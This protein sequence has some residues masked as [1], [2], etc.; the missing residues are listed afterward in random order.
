MKKIVIVLIICSF[1]AC[2][3]EQVSKADTQVY[4]TLKKKNELKFSKKFPQNQKKL[5]YYNDFNSGF[6]SSKWRKETTKNNFYLVDTMSNS[7][8]FLDGFLLTEMNPTGVSGKSKRAEYGITAYDSIGKRKFLS[9]TIK[10]QKDFKYDQVNLGRET[11]I[12]QWHSKPAPGKDWSHYRANNEFNRPSVAL[13]VT[14]NDNK[15]YYLVLRYGNNGKTQFNHKKDV[16]S[17]IALKKIDI[18]QWINLVFEIKWSFNNDGYIASW[19]NNEPFTPFNGLHN[20]VYGANMH[21]KSPAYFKF[22]QYRY[23]DDSNQHQVFF[24]ELRVADDFDEVTLYK[25]Y[26]EMFEV[27]Q[28]HNFIENHK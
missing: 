24:D 13:Y 8:R 6:L 3:T 2:Q 28:K 22:G 14:T 15:N 20:R 11:M 4:Y 12:C 23:F 17:S 5:K 10:I 18:G 19:I 9:F 26:P 21:N 25:D 7:G 1:W 16:W 27:A